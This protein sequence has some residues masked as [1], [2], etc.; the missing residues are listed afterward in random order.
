MATAPESVTVAVAARRLGLSVRSV[1]RLFE[2][3]RLPH[4][5]TDGGHLRVLKVDLEGFIQ[6]LQNRASSSPPVQTP[7]P[8]SAPLQ[9]RRERIDALRLDAEELRAKRELQKLQDEQ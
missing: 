1:K 3:G 5:R 8:V 9:Q 7:A 4:F 2:A 6:S